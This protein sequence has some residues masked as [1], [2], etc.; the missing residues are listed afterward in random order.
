MKKLALALCLL[1]S[2]TFAAE[3]CITSQ[4]STDL[5]PMKHCETTA[6]ANMGYF[7]AAMGATFFPQGFPTTVGGVTTYAPPTAQQIID[8][9]GAAIWVGEKNNINSYLAE[10]AKAAA[11]AGAPKIQ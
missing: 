8:A 9:A 6:D 4:L 2:P 5:A 11:A 1:A 7:V 10:Q 3:F